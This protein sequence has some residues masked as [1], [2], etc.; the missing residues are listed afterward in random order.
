MVYPHREYYLA[1]KN[2]EVLI[3]ATTGMNLENS[4]L[5]EEEHYRRPHAVKI[6]FYMKLGA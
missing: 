3:H 1:I 4:I 5:G 2:T 6:P